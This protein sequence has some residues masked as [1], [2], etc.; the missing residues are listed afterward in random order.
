MEAE[1]DYI[2]KAIGLIVDDDLQTIDVESDQ[3]NKYHHR[4]QSRLAGTTWNSGCSSWYLTADGYNGTMY[5]GFATQFAR[6]LARVKT[7]DYV[8]TPKTSRLVRSAKTIA[9]PDTPSAVAATRTAAD[10]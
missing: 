3:Q 2:V 1:I 6:Q 4:L 10:G 9:T 5:P 8:M 7:N